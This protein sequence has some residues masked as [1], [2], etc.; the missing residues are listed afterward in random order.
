MKPKD[1]M[2]I[3]HRGKHRCAPKAWR[4]VPNVTG[5]YDLDGTIAH[6]TNTDL[7]NRLALYAKGDAYGPL[8][9]YDGYHGY[10]GDN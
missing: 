9:G 3:G 6:R 7:P 8:T 10:R 1:M 2:Q 5:D 4:D